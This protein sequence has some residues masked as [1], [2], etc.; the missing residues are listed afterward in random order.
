MNGCVAGCNGRLLTCAPDGG[1]REAFAGLTLAEDVE[2]A[3]GAELRQQTRPFG[4]LQARVERG[5][6]R[7]VQHFQNVPFCP[8]SPFLITARQLLL[9]HDLGGEDGVSGGGLE[10]GQEDGADVAGA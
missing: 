3:T 1:F 2:V 4:R 10:L 7:V 5:Q 6:E 8:R 9:V